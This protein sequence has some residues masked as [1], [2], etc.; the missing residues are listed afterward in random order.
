M[1][2]PDTSYAQPSD[3]QNIGLPAAFFTGDLSPSL[4]QQQMFLDEAKSHIDSLIDVC[5]DI[6]LPLAPPFDPMLIRCNVAISVWNML[7][8]R[9][10]NPES[11]TDVSIRVRYEDCLK[12]LDKIATGRAKLKNQVTKPNP[13]GQQPEVM[14]SEDRGLRNWSG[15]V[16]SGAWR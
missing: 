5:S 13:M 14:C 12:W 11:P 4:A 6:T 9:G 10:Y 8:W 15:F 16:G 7:A 2:Y 1:P 3:L